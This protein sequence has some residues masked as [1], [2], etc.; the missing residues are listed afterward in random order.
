MAKLEFFKKK[1]TIIVMASIGTVLVL[2]ISG[3]MFYVN[4][5]VGEYENKILPGVRVNS[6]DLSGKTKE[7]ALNELHSQYQEVILKK[8]IV[9]NGGEK[10]Y[11]L[12]YGDLNAE[13]NITDVLDKALEGS[14]GKSTF[15]MYKLIK[16]AEDKLLELELKYDTEAVD[17]MVNT[18]ETDVFK[19]AKNA[20]LS[21]NSDGTFS[22]TPDSNGK[23]LDKETLIA[24]VKSKLSE[25]GNEDII[26][27][28]PIIDEEASRKADELKGIDSKIATFST[29][30]NGAVE[31]PRVQNI[32]LCTQTLNGLLYMPGEQFS[33]E[34]VVGDTTKEKGYKKAGVIVN[35]KIVDDYGGGICQVST[36]MYNAVLRSNIL[37]TER[38]FHSLPSSY[39]GLGMDA[40]IA[41]G[42]LDYKFKNTLD[43][44]IYIEGIISNGKVIFNV[45]SNSSLNNFTYNIVNEVVSKTPNTTEY[46]DD[47]TLAKGVQ[48]VDREG[49]IG[50]KVNVYKIKYDKN[51]NEVE[52]V[53]IN[54]DDYKAVSKVIKRG[55]KVAAVVKPEETPEEV[56]EEVPEETPQGDPEE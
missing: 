36:T 30:L 5:T 15:D 9:F 47:N 28:L 40:T 17:T 39:I 34:S 14:K 42:Y 25:E 37:P 52:R 41:S 29:N 7:E 51:K 49:N 2:S 22:V 54:T 26:V 44:P 11:S 1:S 56:P 43:Y 38:H 4:K 33:F 46:I 16:K 24:D 18:I 45:Y 50:H 23:K 35:N 6:L 20:T 27:E 10:E 31:S 21:K 32:S 12:N 19:A 8:N 55:T 3:F 48:K 13:Y 53:L